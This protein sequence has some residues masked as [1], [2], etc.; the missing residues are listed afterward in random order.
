MQPHTFNLPDPLRSRYTTNHDLNIM[1]LL[2]AIQLPLLD[3]FFSS[4]HSRFYS[5][6]RWHNQPDIIPPLLRDNHIKNWHMLHQWAEHHRHTFNPRI[7]KVLVKPSHQLKTVPYNMHRKSINPILRST[8]TH[9]CQPHK[10]TFMHHHN[11]SAT[12][13][14]N[15]EWETKLAHKRV[16]NHTMFERWKPSASG[17][18]PTKQ[19]KL[20]ALTVNRIYFVDVAAPMQNSHSTKNKKWIN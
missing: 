9:N 7:H 5:S 10:N 8:G 6:T 17:D 15:D 20:L 19:S 16:R 13:T 11:E 12:R 14:S 18:K 4:W 2:R 1:S 3:S